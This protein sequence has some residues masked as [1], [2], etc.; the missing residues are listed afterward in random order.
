MNFANIKSIAIPEGVVTKIVFGASVLWEKIKEGV[1]YIN[2]VPISID[3]SGNIFNGSGYKAGYRL[4]SS[5][6]E[7]TLSGS[8]VTGYIPAKNGDVVRFKGIKWLRS[9]TYDLDSKQYCYISCFNS[10]FGHAAS[11]GNNASTDRF[12][13]DENGVYTLNNI[14]AASTAYIRISGI[15]NGEDLVVTVNEEIIE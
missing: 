7:K 2:Q 15:G 10:T 9:E 13:K 4:S 5:G 14:L 12:T 11:Y 3:T 8:V 6:V 1:S